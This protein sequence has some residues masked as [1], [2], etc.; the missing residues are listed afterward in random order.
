MINV[1]VLI[2]VYLLIVCLTFIEYVLND[3]NSSGH[4]VWD[5]GARQNCVLYLLILMRVCS[6]NEFVI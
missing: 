1:C 3:V 4:Y 5:Q 6:D 2:P